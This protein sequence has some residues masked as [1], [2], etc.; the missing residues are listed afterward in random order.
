MNEHI[1]K[2][3]GLRSV[4]RADRWAVGA[5]LLAGAAW[6]AKTVMEVRLYAAGE[7]HSGPPARGG[8][9]RPL[10]ALENAYHLVHSVCGGTALVCAFVFIAWLWRVRDNGMVLSGERPR[11]A[12]FWVYAGWVVP[13]VNL[14]V[15]RGLIADVYRSSVPGRRPP[16][17]LNVWWGLCLVGSF[18]GVG[19]FGDEPVEKTIERA[20]SDIGPLVAYDAAVVGA[21]VAGA[22]LVRAVTAAQLERLETWTPPGAEAPAVD[23][24][25]PRTSTG[26]DA[27]TEKAP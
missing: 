15:P 17:V 12:G 24:E 19:L 21:A 16:W 14:W 27:P 22:F 7:P 23:L 26:C 10:T 2:H 5:L 25:K 18:G 4:H 9:H 1:A 11:Y 20:Y 6:A 8:E 3:P 13:L